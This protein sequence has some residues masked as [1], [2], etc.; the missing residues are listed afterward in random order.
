MLLLAYQVDQCWVCR[1]KWWNPH[2]AWSPPGNFISGHIIC[3][4]VDNANASWIHAQNPL[5]TFPRNFPVDREVANLLRTFYGE[6]GVGLMDFGLYCMNRYDMI[7]H[8]DK[9]LTC[10]WK[11]IEN[12]QFNLVHGAKLKQETREVKERKKSKVDD[13]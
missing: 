5:D 6:T 10:A 7:W 8:D 9:D 12:C 11:L 2:G 4:I 3:D 13:W 1:A